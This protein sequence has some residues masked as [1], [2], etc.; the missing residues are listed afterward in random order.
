M[1]P[2]SLCASSSMTAVGGG[3]GGGG[4]SFGG[5]DMRVPDG[6]AVGF[7]GCAE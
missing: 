3:G 6:T 1:E 5:W 2:G 7:A 4:T